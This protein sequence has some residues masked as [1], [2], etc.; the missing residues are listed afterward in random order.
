[1]RDR[2]EVRTEAA[3]ETMRPSFSVYLAD[4]VKRCSLHFTSNLID[5][6][7]LCPCWSW[8]CEEGDEVQAKCLT[9][10]VG[11]TA[12]LFYWSTAWSAT[13]GRITAWISCAISAKPFLVTR[14]V[15]D[16]FAA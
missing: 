16:S 14:Y 3:A 11:V 6:I 4:K 5:K 7:K 1:M 2:E 15:F 13:R 12:P 8:N 10:W 9:G